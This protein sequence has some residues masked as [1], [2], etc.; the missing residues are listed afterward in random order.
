MKADVDLVALE[1]LKEQG[2]PAPDKHKHASAFM[3]PLVDVRLK[4][5]KSRVPVPAA[6]SIADSKS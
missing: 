5:I 2:L 6:S 1:F 3:Q 4:E